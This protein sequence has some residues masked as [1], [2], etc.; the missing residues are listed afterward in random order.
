MALNLTTKAKKT[1][2]EP[3]K[4]S[5]TIDPIKQRLEH[6][7]GAMDIMGKMQ[8]MDIKG[9]ESDAKVTALH[10]KTYQTVKK[11]EEKPQ[12]KTKTEKKPASKATK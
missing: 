7:S 6:Q 11:T 2:A 8:D 10:A 12:E 1:N 9:K 4:G 5:E 3:P